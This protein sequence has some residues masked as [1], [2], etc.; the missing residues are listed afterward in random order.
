[1]L[2]GAII[3]NKAPGFTST[4]YTEKIKTIINQKLRKLYKGQTIELIEKAGHTGTLDPAASGVLVILINNATKIIPFLS[5]EKSYTFE[6]I[7]GKETDTLDNCGQTIKE[8][9]ISNINP[10]IKKIEEILPSYI[11]KFTQK[12]PLYSSKKIQGQRLYQIARNIQNNTDNLTES[13]NQKI[14]TVNI[15]SV[16]VISHYYQNNYHRAQLEI[17]CSQGTYIRSFIQDLS[18][19]IQVPLTLSFLVR[20]NS[21]NFT[22]QQALT[23]EKIKN[24]NIIENLI[25]PLENILNNFSFAIVNDKSV[26][27]VRNGHSF[28][29]Q[30]IIYLEKKGIYNDKNIFVVKDRKKENIAIAISN[31]TINFKVKKVLKPF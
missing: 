31:D 4:Q 24:E 18:E 12:A 10:I 28:S 21:N 25:I 1:M 2:N 3:V 15:N 30:Q 9:T 7:I 27:K 6:I 8:I 22:I 26:F 23:I 19:K 16:K 5:K 20:K 11:G 14:N 17:E 13:I 29:N